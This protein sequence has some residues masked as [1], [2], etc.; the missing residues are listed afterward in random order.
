MPHISKKK[1]NKEDFNKIYKSFLRSFGKFKDQGASDRFFWEFLT[2]T[3]KV[4]FSKRLAIILL[5]NRGVSHYAIWNALNVSPSTVER[6]AKRLDRGG[7]IEI[8]KLL[9]EDG[10]KLLKVLEALFEILTPP[11][12]HLSRAKF[13]EAKRR[14][15]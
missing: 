1:L 7:Y 9:K 5:L 11:P 8:L 2:P 12:Y 6:I 10:G 14:G 13:I 4:M 15:R 3:E